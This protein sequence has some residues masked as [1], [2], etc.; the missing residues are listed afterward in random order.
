MKERPII[1]KA[2]MVRAILDGEKTQSLDSNGHRAYQKGR[3]RERC[4]FCFLGAEYHQ[5]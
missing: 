1:F 3:N 2:E 5:F 4:L